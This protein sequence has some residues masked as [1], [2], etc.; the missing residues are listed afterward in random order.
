MVACSSHAGGAIFES[1]L[2]QPLNVLRLRLYRR[3]NHSEHPFRDVWLPV[4]ALMTAII[5]LCIGTSFAK[6]LFAAVGAQGTTAYRI[7]VG[8]IIL[9]LWFRPWRWP[10]NQSNAVKIL[11]YGIVLGLMNLLFYMSL[12]TLPLGIA[13]AIEF[14]GPL[15]LSV[16]N[17]RRA[18]DFFWVIIA[19]A[20]LLLL[21]P[22]G[23]QATHLDPV[24]VAYALGASVFWVLYIIYGKSAGSLP[25][26]QAV[27]LGMITAAVLIIPFGVVE[28]GTKLLDPSLLL[29]GLGIGVLA[30]ALPYSLEMIALRKLPY[31]TF[32]VMLSM[33][34]AIG[35][36]AAAIILNEQLTMFQTLAIACIVTASAGSAATAGRSS[37]SNPITSQG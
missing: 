37:Q 17:S 35:A 11:R 7:T 5:S 31:K 34:P 25:K 6:T 12:K 15:L 14:T 16:F 2:A 3:L 18:L 32:G 24:G 22:A 20:G 1:R 36:I 13:I 21:I 30:S 26:G 28:A 27:S 23:E 10:L 29:A 4:L 19:G 33:E 9:T 8:A